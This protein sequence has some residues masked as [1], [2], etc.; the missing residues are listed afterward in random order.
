MVPFIKEANRPAEGL[1][2]SV[3]V[4][5]EAPEGGRKA[6]R[7]CYNYQGRIV[8]IIGIVGR[9]SCDGGLED[10][11]GPIGDKMGTKDTDFDKLV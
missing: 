3:Q 9:G 4:G 11:L 7:V 6:C 1:L 2:R 5:G 8:G 10:T